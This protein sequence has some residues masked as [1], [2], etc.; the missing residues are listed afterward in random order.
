M[1]NGRKGERNWGGFSGLF[2]GRGEKRR[3]KMILERKGVE[4]KAEKKIYET[5]RSVLGVELTILT[6]TVCVIYF[7]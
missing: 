6:F 4:I 5:H 2:E 7:K 3:E 1:K